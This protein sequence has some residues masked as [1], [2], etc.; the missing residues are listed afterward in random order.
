MKYTFQ[1]KIVDLVKD[2]HQWISQ[3]DIQNILQRHEN[4]DHKSQNG[5]DL[6]LVLGYFSMLNN[7]EK[8]HKPYV[9]IYLCAVSSFLPYQAL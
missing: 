3:I 7:F 5:D 8:L 4:S 6:V 9:Y 1:Q 2:W